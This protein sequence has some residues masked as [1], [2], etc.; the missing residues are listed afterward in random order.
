MD[1]QLVITGG[2]FSLGGVLIGAL[3]TPLTQLFLEW[4]R[5]RRAADR[6][7]LLVSGELLQAQMILRAVS[8]G[9]H[10]PCYEDPN[11]F[12]PTSAWRENRSSIVG[13]VSEDL[14]V[15][16]VMAYSLLEYDRARFA[17]ANKIPAA[18]PL[19]AEVAKGM[20]EEAIKLG[21]LRRQLGLGGG[22]L[23]EIE[24]ELKLET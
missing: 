6:A 2:L 19:T 21:R 9:E 3:L 23:D 15:Q 1:L 16:I 13:K 20:K 22:W 4:K 24:E 7:M 11:A 14:W 12:L 5:E 10:W 18:T 8:E 17:L